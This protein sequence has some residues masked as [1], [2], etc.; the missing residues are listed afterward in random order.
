MIDLA[1][2]E[3]EKHGTIVA[4]VANIII[5]LMHISLMN[6]SDAKSK[7]IHNEQVLHESMNE[8]I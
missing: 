2:K 3:S 5:T 8:G 7:G 4:Q 6:L 1:F